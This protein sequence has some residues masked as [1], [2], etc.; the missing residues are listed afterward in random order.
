MKAASP[1]DHPRPRPLNLQFA[2]S[3]S[4]DRSHA[5]VF[6]FLLSFLVDVV[7][8]CSPLAAVCVRVCGRSVDAMLVCVRGCKA[9]DRQF[10]LSH[11]QLPVAA[12]ISLLRPCMQLSHALLSPVYVCARH[13]LSGR[14]RLVAPL[15]LLASGR[16]WSDAALFPLHPGGQR[17]SR[18][19]CV[20]PGAGS[21]GL[22]CGVAF[23]FCR[24]SCP[25]GR[26]CPVPPAFLA[27]LS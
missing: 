19:T 12:H 9:A 25:W 27:I 20:T 7:Q 21:N 26:P 22:H 16:C 14:L 11:F 10:V 23:V 18:T 13:H 1:A 5:H 24:P 17:L 6:F 4:I 8:Q 2:R 3:L 15:H